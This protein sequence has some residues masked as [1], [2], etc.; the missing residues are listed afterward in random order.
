MRQF[1]DNYS[2]AVIMRP[3]ENELNNQKAVQEM[4]DIRDAIVEERKRIEALRK[5][6]DDNGGQSNE[7]TSR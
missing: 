5:A 4:R 6:G 2:G 1:R 7:D 3:S